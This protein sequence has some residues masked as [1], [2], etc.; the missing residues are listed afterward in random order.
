MRQMM[1]TDFVGHT[2]ANRVEG[3]AL[4]LVRDA[5]IIYNFMS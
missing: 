4:S 3:F 2:A 5:K 1:K